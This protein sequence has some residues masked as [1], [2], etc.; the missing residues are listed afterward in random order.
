[1][2]DQAH[3]R[4]RL[5]EWLEQG[6]Q[7]DLRQLLSPSGWTSL[8]HEMEHEYR[9]RALSWSVVD[10]LMKNPEGRQTL[11]AFMARLKEHRGLHSLEAIEHTFP[12]GAGAFERQWLEHVET[13]ALPD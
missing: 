6:R 2:R 1:V 9:V 5:A 10:F 11:R 8:G 12:G 7:P 13:R 4:R 3:H